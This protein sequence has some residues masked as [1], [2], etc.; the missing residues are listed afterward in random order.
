MLYYDTDSVIYSCKP[1]EV[2]IPTGVFLGQMTDEL[3]GDSISVFGS[4]GP[5]SYCYKTNGGK[6]ECKNK[7]TKSSYEINQVLNCTSMMQHIQKE[8]SDPLEQRR[9][10][11]INIKNH[12]VTDNTRKTVSLTDLVKVFGV[13]WDKR[14][15][16]KGTGVTYP[17]GYV[18]I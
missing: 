15:V 10:M 4:A 11:N 5:K 16:E 9:L 3:D 6:S 8:L 18:R 7:G 14:V 12:F 13:N 17:Y 1:G 2:K